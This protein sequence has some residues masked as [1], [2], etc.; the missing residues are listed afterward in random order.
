MHYGIDE[1]FVYAIR[2]ETLTYY[3]RR[4]DDCI[5]SLMRESHQVSESAPIGNCLFCCLA[6]LSYIRVISRN[7]LGKV[8]T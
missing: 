6:T 5:K 7:Q 8:I 3:A 4:L 2:L 1:I